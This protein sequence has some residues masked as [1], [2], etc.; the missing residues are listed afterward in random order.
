MLL[1]GLF[2]NRLHLTRSSSQALFAFRVSWKV[3]KKCHICSG[4]CRCREEVCVWYM[5]LSISLSAIHFLAGLSFPGLSSF[6]CLPPIHLSI[7]LSP[8]CVSSV[9]IM[10]ATPSQTKLSALHNFN[11]LAKWQSCS[12]LNSLGGRRKSLTR[13]LFAVCHYTWAE[14]PGHRQMCIMVG[15]GGWT[16]YGASSNKTCTMENAHGC[17]S[18]GCQRLY[19]LREQTERLDGILYRRG[20]SEWEYLESHETVKELFCGC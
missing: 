12:G 3:R 16:Q 5:S 1:Q 6:L 19:V 20:S 9:Y 7:L 13:G 17:I 4:P 15:G 18:V 11:L 14:T 2:G 10:S 8:M